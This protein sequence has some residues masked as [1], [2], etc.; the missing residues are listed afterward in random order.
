MA[1]LQDRKNSRTIPITG[2]VTLIG[3]DP[4]CDIVV[5]VPT[6]SSRH[7]IILHT[8]DSY[9][10]ED[11]GSL[12]GTLV[13][14]RKVLKR[15]PL[16]HGDHI[17]LPGLSVKLELT[18]IGGDA[19]GRNTIMMKAL[20]KEDPARILS[21]IEIGS[22][23][24][25]GV[26]TEVKLRAVL[27]IVRNLGTNLDFRVVLPKTLESLF[28]IFPH[29]DCGFILLVDDATGQLVPKAVKYRND[30][31]NQTVSI[32]RGIVEHV[33]QTG[34]A[35][36]SADAGSDARFNPT[37]SI[38]DLNIRSFI[39]A[40]LVGQD[41][42]SFGVVQIDSRN[43]QH[44]FHPDDLDLLACTSV[45][46]AR[47]VELG[48]M[49]EERREMEA[50]TRIQKSFLPAQRPPHPKLSFYDHY[51]PALQVSGDYFDYIQLPDGRLAMA[52][53]D[54]SGKGISAALLMARVSA[55]VRFTLATAPTVA[56]A[57]RELNRALLRTGSEERFV[58]FVVVVI[59]V[60]RSR[61][62]IV[63]AGHLPPLLK[64]R[65][66]QIREIGDEAV[67]LP[68]AVMDRPYDEVQFEIE[69]GDA[70]LLYTDGVTEARNTDHEMYGRDRLRDAVQSAPE[71]IEAIGAAVLSDVR[72]FA[73]KRP[74]NDDLTIVGFGWRTEP[75]PDKNL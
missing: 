62:T 10:I 60:E 12:G 2:K 7:A 73:G 3:R 18:G 49:N 32:S 21:S 27:E 15:T 31:D 1:V 5:P 45:L 19:S 29:A 9:S 48:R 53:G 11:L 59:D 58:T 41:G 46:A 22:E 66:Q 6:T 37:R 35:V 43:W 40:P 39:C 42:K 50:A 30:P 23:T 13:N 14:G 34:R 17:D 20:P 52:I 33:L 38:Q 69:P 71:D 16:V 63:N 4:A 64:R 61:I 36:L 56:L 44:Q 74:Q 28:G 26:Q 75:T 65:G 47:A 25:L 24:R 54:V 67:G 72:D 68:L 8:G 57:V 51:S 70:L 55:A